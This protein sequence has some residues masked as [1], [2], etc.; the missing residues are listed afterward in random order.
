LV[1]KHDVSL[2]T[3][4]DPFSPK[5]VLTLVELLEFP[6][7]SIKGNFQNANHPQIFDTARSTVISFSAFPQIW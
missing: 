1:V 5:A 2:V 4:R 7:W 6:D 3:K